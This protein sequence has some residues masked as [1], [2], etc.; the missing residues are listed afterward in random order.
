MEMSRVARRWNKT[1]A[2]ADQRDL[3]QCIACQEKEDSEEKTNETRA[4][5]KT[6][7]LA[8]YSG[9]RH[10]QRTRERGER[11]RQRLC[12]GNREGAGIRLQNE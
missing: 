7:G 6:Q 1:F 9:A 10:S 4:L 11:R 2:R 3:K 8:R 12:E 5:D